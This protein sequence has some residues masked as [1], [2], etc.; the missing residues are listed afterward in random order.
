MATVSESLKARTARTLLM[1]LRACKRH[2]T[3][4]ARTV[5]DVFFLFTL[6]WFSLFSSPRGRGAAC[7]P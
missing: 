7:F 6:V 3:E 1:L 5:G 4:T 2:S